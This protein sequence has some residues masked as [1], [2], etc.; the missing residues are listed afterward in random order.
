MRK[1]T[2][3]RHRQRRLTLNA[4]HIARIHQV[5]A[6]PGLAPGAALHTDLDYVEW[7]DTM[8]RTHPDPS[9]RTWLFAYGS[10]IWKP[11]IEHVDDQLGSAR[12]WHRTFCF[13]MHR[14]RG[15]PEQPGLMMALDRGG[16]CQGVL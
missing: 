7:V 8:I 12:G 5:V 4:E 2:S 14:F 11:E 16:Q 1:G 15:T 6:D 3:M 9:G 10:L 13:R